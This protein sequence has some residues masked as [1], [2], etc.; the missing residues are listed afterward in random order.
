MTTT[1]YRTR[2]RFTV[3]TPSERVYWTTVGAPVAPTLFDTYDDDDDGGRALIDPPADGDCGLYVAAALVNAHTG[4]A[5]ST[6]ELRSIFV[7]M[8]ATPP[9]ERLLRNEMLAEGMRDEPPR[10]YLS[11]ITHEG[12][13]VSYTLVAE[14]TAF[15]IYTLV[16]V[17][18]SLRVY[19]PVGAALA[20]DDVV[21]DRDDDDVVGRIMHETRLG[22]DDDDD[23]AADADA[24]ARV[25]AKGHFVFDRPAQHF[26]LV[27]V[28]SRH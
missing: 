28:D 26:L 22:S 8:W 7:A 6:R 15:L 16:G 11:S 13:Y 14:A 3:Q 4:F 5:F 21:A 23:D 9:F 25:S 17:R 18:V 27:V 19:T 12:Q 24:A 2:R 20:S 1:M 10:T